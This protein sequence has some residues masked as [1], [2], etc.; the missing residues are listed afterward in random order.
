MSEIK[1]QSPTQL[2]FRNKCSSFQAFM[3]DF[4]D[5]I[6]R[7]LVMTL[8]SYLCVEKYGKDQFLFFQSYP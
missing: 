8:P 1:L 5:I 4:H 6:K 3:K 2:N 7:F